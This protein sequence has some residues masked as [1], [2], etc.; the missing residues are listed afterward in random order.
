M[1]LCLGWS[2]GL[3]V[4]QAYRFLFY[5]G[6]T[7]LKWKRGL[8][9]GFRIICCKFALTIGKVIILLLLIQST[10]RSSTQ[11]CMGWKNEIESFFQ[12]FFHSHNHAPDCRRVRTL[13]SGLSIDK[14]AIRCVITSVVP[15]DAMLS[16]TAAKAKP[17]LCSKVCT[18]TVR[19]N[20]RRGSL[21]VEA[22]TKTCK[23]SFFKTKKR[24]WTELN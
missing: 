4:G 5:R 9:H 23:I 10:A 18:H 11:V 20:C 19:R 1:D 15:A 16:L 21:G 2:Q 17:T 7:L 6:K 3:T 8:Y 12:Q 24:N 14:F 13:V 22:L